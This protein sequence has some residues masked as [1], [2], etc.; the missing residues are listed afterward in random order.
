MFTGIVENQGKVLANRALEA[1]KLLKIEANLEGLQEGESISINGVCL[2]LLPG[3]EQAL[4]FNVS[5]E[6]LEKTNL[7]EMVP[8][9]KIN[10]ERA[11]LSSTR[12]GGHYVSGHIDK[13]IPLLKK[14]IMGDFVE[15]IIGEFTPQDLHYLPNKGSITLEGVSLTINAVHAN[16]AQLLLIPY[17]L[18][19]TN[20]G[21]KKEGDLLN[22]EFDYLTKIVAHQLSLHTSARVLA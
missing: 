13:K 7:G 3:F 6:T 19:K 17:T 16:T 1:G 10:I 9:E 5:K 20:L 4:S 2:T 12:F 18:E 14:Q 11:M 15:L 21:T 8:G 22:V